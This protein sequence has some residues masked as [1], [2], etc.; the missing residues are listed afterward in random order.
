MKKYSLAIIGLILFC[1]GSVWL[2][3][4]FSF[5]VLPPSQALSSF[6]RSFDGWTGDEE[7]LSDGVANIL[8]AH[9]MLSLRFTRGL[10]GPVF[11]HASTWIAPDSV[12][13]TCPHHPDICYRGNGWTPSDTTVIAIETTDS[14]TIPVQVSKM[15]RGDARVIVAFTY[16]MGDQFFADELAARSV[17]LKQ[18]GNS[19]WPSV[20][21]FMVQTPHE[22]VEDAKP[23]IEYFTKK[24]FFWHDPAPQS[25]L[26][27]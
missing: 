4:G 27:N 23:T 5:S 12:S 13:E 10:D 25:S 8:D 3:R 6:P 20:T 16:R 2:Q 22:S 17:Q 21:K 11:V 14:R 1:I 18:F 19:T 9:E 15:G 26:S 7:E 24:F